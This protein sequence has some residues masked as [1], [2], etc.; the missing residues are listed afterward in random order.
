MTE[1]PRYVAFI[2]NVMIGRA[3]LHRDL[4]L[5]IFIDAGATDPRSHLATG[6]VS[7]GSDRDEMTDLIDAAQA[8]IAQ[9]MGRFEPVFVRSVMALRNL[10]RVHAVSNHAHSRC[11]SPMRDI[12]GIVESTRASGC[13]IEKT[14]NIDAIG[15]DLMSVT[16]WSRAGMET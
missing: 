6:N 9:T 3:G 4:L 7:F 5:R 15:A 13:L 16:D 1:S 10:G 2:R 14:R 12:H 11:R 8:R